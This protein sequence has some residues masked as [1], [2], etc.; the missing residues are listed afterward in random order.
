MITIQVLK[1]EVSKDVDRKKIYTPVD[2]TNQVIM[3]IIDVERLDNTLDTSSIS[4]INT[5]AEAIRPFT[6]MIIRLDDG[7]TKKNIYRLVYTDNVELLT[8]GLSKTYQHNIEL[9]EPT[10][11]L[12]RF[13]V[14]N[15]TITNLL[16]FLYED[17]YTGKE[18]IQPFYKATT[19]ED[20]SFAYVFGI[21]F[22]WDGYKQG[23]DYRPFYATYDTNETLD[24]SK[25]MFEVYAKA[26]LFG[27]PVQQIDVSL[28]YCTISTP[29][30]TTVAFNGGQ[31]IQSTFALTEPGKYYVRQIYSATY[32]QY[33][34]TREY[35]WCFTVL[36]ASQT[37]NKPQRKTIAETLQIVLQR[38]GDET[39]L[40]RENESPMF[41]VEA[42]T[43]QKYNKIQ[44]PEFTFSQN[45]L[46]GILEQ[47]GET[48]HSIP[49]LI[50]N[51]VVGEDGEIDDWSNW[52]L[53][54]FD[55]LGGDEEATSGQVISQDRSF[56]GDN[57][58]TNYVTN[59]ENSFQ[60]NKEDYIAITEPYDG[61]FIS[62]RTEASDF[63]V[64]A[65]SAC[66]KLSRPV[67]R[68]IKVICRV[69]NNGTPQDIDITPYVKEA[70]DYSLLD[71][72]TSTSSAVPSIGSKEFAIY[73]TRG[74]NVIRGLD[75]IKPVKWTVQNLWTYQAIFNILHRASGQTFNATWTVGWQMPDLMFQV[76]YVPYYGLKLKQ[77]KGTIRADSGNNELFFNQQN[78]QMVDIEAY[79][80]N[81]KGALLRTANEEISRTEY[82]YNLAD[83][84]KMGQKR[85]D[86]YAYQINKE[87][88]NYR[89]KTT[90]EYSKNWNKWNEYVA[91]KKN[92]RQWEISERES[93]N[94]N[95]VKNEFCI[96]RNTTSAEERDLNRV[97]TSWSPVDPEVTLPT[98]TNF[99]GWLITEE[100]PTNAEITAFAEANF[101]SEYDQLQDNDEVIVETD[102]KKYKCYYNTITEEWTAYEAT[103]NYNTGNYVGTIVARFAGNRAPGVSITSLPKT[104]GFENK[105]FYSLDETRYGY[106]LFKT[107]TQTDFSTLAELEAAT[108][109]YDYQGQQKYTN[110]GDFA[111]VSSTQKVYT[112][113]LDPQEGE[114]WVET[115]ELSSAPVYEIYPSALSAFTSKATGGADDGDLVYVAYYP[116]V[117]PTFRVYKYQSGSWNE[118]QRT[119]LNKRNENG[120]GINN[121][122]YLLQ[123]Y[124]DDGFA[125]RPSIMQIQGRLADSIIEGGYKAI[126]W[127]VMKTISTEYSQGN[128]QDVEH[129]FIAPCAC[130]SFGNSIVVNFETRDNYAA[131][132]YIEDDKTDSGKKYALEGNVKYS[133][134]YGNFNKF[135]LVFG[136]GNAKK[137]GFDSV[138]NSEA[139]SKE[140]YKFDEANID[141]EKV[142]VDYR[143]N[144]FQLVKD[145]RQQIS[146][147]G[148]LHFVSELE[149]VTYGKAFAQAMPFVGNT[150]NASGAVKFVAFSTKPDKFLSQKA[151]G[152][153]TLQNRVK[154]NAF[155]KTI[156]LEFRNTTLTNYV[157]F[158]LIDRDDNIMLY[159]D[160]E[161]KAL[162]TEKLYLEIKHDI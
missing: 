136:G 71:D 151:T 135:T 76:K 46:F 108:T 70:T 113:Q 60:T 7:T 43:M 148:Q 10:K 41:S 28:S 80:E 42:E 75:Y 127:A 79:G 4:L 150:S 61:G 20:R 73:Y 77:Y 92:Y 91:I 18:V 102:G 74:D 72:Y 107:N 90:T 63:E 116:T 157:G 154:Y 37:D 1:I 13:E 122:D 119:Q 57:Y 53:I 126:D 12:E 140:F 137:N 67:Q 85:G 153:Q 6:R 159:F 34:I 125:S 133:D 89:V 95:P 35:E 131:S 3:P 112:Y 47:I 8:Y 100:F 82:F 94:T 69:N 114:K 87:I 51:E 144:A 141:E 152:Y 132:T 38:V 52:N 31:W 45:T 50:P 17:P 158:G 16:T 115:E 81:V 83:V 103:P 66:I 25:S 124:S 146:Y 5:E 162:S 21:F 48:I 134:K 110:F 120:Y 11:W 23:D 93:V 145:S 54:T 149:E 97:I 32:N 106:R 155:T 96:A 142:L 68:I 109:F 138:A 9:I 55:E 143:E 128:Y 88:T 27:I 44:S 59:V 104:W 84:V 161:I 49:R 14:D 99:W 160:K 36:T 98:Y 24:I 15:T 105:Y 58:A 39:T 56:N 118:I 78:S 19:R 22:D 65:N 40:L 123:Q 111:K 117:E 130:F 121:V 147:T 33:T 139:T 62:A 101:T 2:I 30:G 156:T 29:S 129:T 26:R 64:S 86:F